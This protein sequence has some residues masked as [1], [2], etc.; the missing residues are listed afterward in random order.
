[1]LKSLVKTKLRVALLLGFSATAVLADPVPVPP[2]PDFPV[3]FCFRF[4][5][6]AAVGDD[7]EG[8]QFEFEFE[9][10]NWTDGLATELKLQRNQE[11]RNLQGSAPSFSGAG[12]DANG[13]PLGPEDDDWPPGNTNRLNDWSVGVDNQNVISWNAGTPLPNI[14]LLGTPPSVL[15]PD[16][17]VPDFEVPSPV[18][19]IDP[20][21][22]ETI[23]NGDNVLDGFTFRVDDFDINEII[24]FN[25]EI[26]GPQISPSNGF[27][28]GAVS[29]A[30]K[31]GNFLPQLL[32][33]GNTGFTTSSNVFF[34]NVNE[35]GS[36]TF[37]VEF[38]AGSTA[39][40][41]T[42]VPAPLPIL[43]TLVSLG[44]GIVF[45]RKT[46]ASHSE[47]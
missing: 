8:D 2:L 5:D 23:D 45:K 6:I 7:P 4:T 27:T 32:F 11:N 39:A 24:S 13:R 26:S 21:D 15:D 29:L 28:F 33:L 12:I 9:I 30:R 31:D 38:S 43:G 35:V 22:P 36:S 14:D 37:A 34:N 25:W 40:Q 19:F 42:P 46:T 10:L 17:S 47:S 3:V 1:M 20:G 44:F 16:P 18:S 41:G